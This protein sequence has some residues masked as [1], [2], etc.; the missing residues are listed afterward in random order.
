MSNGQ[1]AAIKAEAEGEAQ[2]LLEKQ[3]KT[4]QDELRNFVHQLRSQLVSKLESLKQQAVALGAVFEDKLSQVAEETSTVTMEADEIRAESRE[5]A[6]AIDQM[7]IGES[8]EKA[9]VSADDLDTTLYERE[10]ELDVVVI[11]PILVTI[12]TK[13]D[14]SPETLTPGSIQLVQDIDSGQIICYT[15]DY[16]H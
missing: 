5:L 4:I 15:G 10:P 8:E 7:N 3:T 14:S 13:F 16:W 1:A 9:L 11:I 12:V 6:Q 2:L